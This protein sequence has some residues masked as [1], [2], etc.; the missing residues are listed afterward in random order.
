MAEGDWAADP[1]AKFPFEQ[2]LTQNMSR[3]KYLLKLMDNFQYFLNMGM[4]REDAADLIR[5]ME[6]KNLSLENYMHD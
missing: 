4:D 3:F 1:E 6:S 5:S 2:E